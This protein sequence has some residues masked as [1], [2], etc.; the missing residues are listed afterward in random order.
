MSFLWGPT[1]QQQ[2]WDTLIGESLLSLSPPPPRPRPHKT[3]SDLLP[4]QTPLD[5]VAALQL[6]DLVRSAS[7]IP[8]YASRSLLR[9]IQHDNP[10]VQLLAL[11][12]CDVCVKNGG[13][14]FLVQFA[15]TA[16]EGGVATDLELLA[17]GVKSG[18]SVHRDVK[19]KVLARLQ[20]WATAFKGKDQ[21]RDS[22]LVRAYD[23]LVKEGVQFPPRDPTATTAMVDSLSAPDW[24]DSPYC[25]RC[26]TE[27]STF[28]RKHHCR[29][30]GQV[31]DQQC[32]SSV[33]PLPHYGILE[34]VRVCD[35]CAKKIREGKGGS[36]Q[37][38]ASYSAGQGEGKR[39]AQVERSKTVGAKGGLSRKEQEDEELRKAIEASLKEVE[40]DQLPRAD[41][42]PPAKSG[43]NP[44][45]ASQISDSKGSSAKKDE[46]DDPDLAAAIAASLRD[47]QPPATAPTFA[48]SESEMT[49]PTSTAYSSLFL[50]STAYDSPSASRPKPMSLPSYDLSATE[51]ALLS[52]FTSLFASP[53]YPPYL[54]PKE[55]R[56]YEEAHAAQGRLDRAMEDARRR[57]EILSEMESK[58]GEAARLYG[59][60]LTERASYRPPLTNRLSSYSATSQAYSQPQHHQPYHAPPAAAQSLDARYQYAPPPALTGQ[61]LPAYAVPVAPVPPLAQHAEIASPPPAQAYSQPPHHAHARAQPQRQPSQAVP[62]G[63]YKSSSFPSVPTGAQGALFPTVPKGELPVEEE[64]EQEEEERGRTGELIEL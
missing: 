13:T 44:S 51:S 18:G 3:T 34:P 6:A 50:S 59:A 57:R 4:A 63:Y 54:G 20:D 24:T 27:F 9:R 28:N 23:K 33:A 48:R 45:Y 60:G 43:Y 7:V 2:E 37:R 31:F 25:T 49:V 10:N 22:E 30:C 32:S 46:E 1:Q 61:P 40:P 19:E 64:R 5:L 26:R 14:A 41:P 56:M 58:L 17:R 16:F 62:A 11:E 53:S 42:G 55:R 38:S 36:V 52:D 35:G 29:N 8:A 21:L 15:K 12:L 47:L 39:P